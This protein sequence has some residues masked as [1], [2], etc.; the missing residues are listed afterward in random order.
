MKATYDRSVIECL[1]L[2]VAIGPQNVSKFEQNQR[3]KLAGSLNLSGYARH[4]LFMTS[5]KL[6]LFAACLLLAVVR[7]F[8][9]SSSIDSSFTGT[10]ILLLSASV[11]N[12]VRGQSVANKKTGQDDTPKINLLYEPRLEA[13]GFHSPIIR[14]SIAGQDAYFLVDTGASVH[15]FARWF[16]E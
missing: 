7:S 5:P 16:A 1:T 10:L 6:P 13:L 15:T 11:T 14:A 12:G 9:Q 2:Y 3:K 8:P 4:S